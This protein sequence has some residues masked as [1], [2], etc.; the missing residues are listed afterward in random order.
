MYHTVTFV[1]TCEH[2]VINALLMLPIVV[3]VFSIVTVDY[4]VRNEN[5]IKKTKQKMLNNIKRWQNK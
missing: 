4:L 3:C 5:K 1:W 2:V